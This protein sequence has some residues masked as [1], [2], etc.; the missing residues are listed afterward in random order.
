MASLHNVVFAGQH[1]RLCTLS[2]QPSPV[3]GSAKTDVHIQLW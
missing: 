1:G 3:D 2:K